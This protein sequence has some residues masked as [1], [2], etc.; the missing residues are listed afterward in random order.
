MILFFVIH[1]PFFLSDE[2]QLDSGTTRESA[3][4]PKT[5]KISSSTTFTPEMTQS[6][7]V[8]SIL[9]S[10]F[11]CFLG[12]FKPQITTF[13]APKI[14]SKIASN[15]ISTPKTTFFQNENDAT[16]T[17]DFEPQI[18][19]FEL[20]ISDFPAFFTNSS[21]DFKTLLE[22]Y[23]ASNWEEKQRI[24]DDLRDTVRNVYIAC[25]VS[26]CVSRF[27]AVYLCIGRGISS[28]CRYCVFILRFTLLEYKSC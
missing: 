10:I 13:Q 15:E 16:Q 28:R 17:T 20:Q 18:S 25:G 4:T 8:F 21:N 14:A 6:M 2:T 27:L 1:D 9:S 7:R 26:V 12:V 19:D 3:K 5:P 23:D 24:G 11:M 22:R